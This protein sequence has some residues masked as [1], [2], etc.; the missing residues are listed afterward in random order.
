MALTTAQHD[1]DSL[2][3]AAEVYVKQYRELKAERRGLKAKR[4][5]EYAK[6]LA[7][8]AVTRL[9]IRR[10]V[11]S[12]VAWRFAGESVRL[13]PD[14]IDTS[15]FSAKTL[16]TDFNRWAREQREAGAAW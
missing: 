12:G 7:Q 4:G 9:T 6:Q 3:H 13:Q 8:D 11:D 1:R 2:R 15:K 16:R 14:K 5:V 10:A